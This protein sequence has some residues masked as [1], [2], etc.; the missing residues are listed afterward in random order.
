M[1]SLLMRT[2]TDI[3]NLRLSR[4]R[5][6]LLSSRAAR[7][8]VLAGCC[9]FA[10]SVSTIAAPAAREEPGRYVVGPSRVESR[11]ENT[12]ARADGKLILDSD[13][14]ILLHYDLSG[15]P[16]S[17]SPHAVIWYHAKAEG[18]GANPAV[19]VYEVESD[20]A[21]GWNKAARIDEAT[22]PINCNRPF[23]LNVTASMESAMRKRSL[24]LL[25]ESRSAPGFSRSVEFSGTPWLCLSKPSGGTF[26]LKEALAPMWKTHRIANE[27]LLPIARDGGP[28][29]ANLAFPPE[30]ILAVRDYSLGKEYV[31]GRDYV[32]EGR[33]LKL[34]PESPIPFLTGS[35]LRP[36][37]KNAKP[38]TLTSWRDG[39]VAFSESSFFNDHELAVTYEH[40]GHWDGPI[41]VVAE[42]S[43][44]RTLRKLR[45]G[46][47]L[48]MVVFGDS[49]CVG[50]SASGKS[51]RTPWMPRWSTLVTKGLASN[52]PGHIDCVNA[53]LGGMR[54][55]WGAKMIDGLVAHEKPDL[56]VLGFGM[57]DGGEN[58]M[59]PQEFAD[60]IRSMMDVVRS[61]KPE[62]EFIL[63]MS[64]QPNPE[65]RDPDPMPAY[66]EAL[67]AMTGPGVALADMW[68]LHG[69]L[70][71]HKSYWDMTGNGVNHPNDF[72]ARLYAQ[73]VLATLGV[74]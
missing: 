46:E 32:I 29:G 4:R 13:S 57:N 21:G 45:Q 69:Y 59:P 43:L 12:A 70:L 22:M 33:T 50:A 19:A 54:S 67:A 62:V 28:G 48:K 65:W 74:E 60:N 58:P 27:T 36:A 31:Q 15:V 20:N 64:F 34:P 16:I 35:D 8:V 30:R 56:V 66:R 71:R 9:C 11:G 55:D 10:A 17:S 44:P 6:R 26:D 18:D 24:T 14:S 47:S 3:A 73:T 23:E 1:I 72:I 49:I 5:H 63:L 40:A 41:P 38:G 51:G 68:S 39:Y 42:E 53:S 25:L 61:T 52:Y 2:H 37:S 7:L